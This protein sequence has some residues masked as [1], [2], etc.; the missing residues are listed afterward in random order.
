MSNNGN[1]AIIPARGG[2]KRIP[3]KN[4]RDFSG[5]PIIAYA[6]ENAVNSELFDRIIVSTDSWKIADISRVYGASVPFLRSNQNADDFATL[7][8]VLLEV[9]EKSNEYYKSNFKYCC[10][11]LPTASLLCV[12]TIV[13]AYSKLIKGQYDCVFPVVEYSYPIQRSLKI[14]KSNPELIEM[15][16][17]EFLSV[18]SQDL[19]KSFHDAGQFYFFDIRNFL[20]NG[21]VWGDNTSFL[22]VNELNVQDIDTEDDW[23]IAELKY[24]LMKK[25]DQ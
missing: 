20:K 24:E 8:D 19:E 10:C 11:I 1:I 22:I 12:K 3:Q 18:R 6:I 25:I 7:N 5:K 23:K 4:I 13:E 15:K 17:P 9:I 21:K 2:S 14:Q 16:Y